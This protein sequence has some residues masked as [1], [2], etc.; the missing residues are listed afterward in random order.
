MIGYYKIITVTHHFF[1]VEEIGSYVVQYQENDQL[2]S[3]LESLKSKFGIEE[4][5]YMATCNRATYILYTPAEIDY[6]FLKEF[7]RFIN[8]RLNPAQ[9]MRLDELVSVYEGLEAI[10]HLF[11]VAIY[12]FLG[13]RGAGNIQAVPRKL[14]KLKSHESIGR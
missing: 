2:A 7:F 9:I 10:R 11:E 8:P 1:P 12:R 3:K 5:Q 6:E 4:L 13:R 14:R